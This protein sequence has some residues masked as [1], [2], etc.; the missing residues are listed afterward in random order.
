MS[1]VAVFTRAGLRYVINIYTWEQ[2]EY[3][4]NCQSRWP[5]TCF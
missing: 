2:W 4:E 1:G 5:R 3:M